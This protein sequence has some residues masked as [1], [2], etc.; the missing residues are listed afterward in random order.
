MLTPESWLRGCP[1]WP[2]KPIPPVAPFYAGAFAGTRALAAHATTNRKTVLMAVHRT[3]RW[4]TRL[5]QKRSYSKPRWLQVRQRIASPSHTT[6]AAAPTS[7]TVKGASLIKD[8]RLGLLN[9][10]LSPRGHKRSPREK[11]LAEL[12]GYSI[13]SSP[14]RG[15]SNPPKA[16]VRFRHKAMA[17]GTQKAWF[18]PTFVSQYPAGNCA[19]C[20]ISATFTV[21][22]RNWIL[23]FII[24]VLVPCI[25]FVTSMT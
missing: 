14:G 2:A 7:T 9:A 4:K 20:A 3:N 23:S 16:S 13:R 22:R 21:P 11:S 18:R 17:S 19:T 25:A 1:R 15:L 12:L 10:G 6:S 8:T 5:E 24:R